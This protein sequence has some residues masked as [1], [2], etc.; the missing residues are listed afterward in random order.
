VIWKEGLAYLR[1][2]YNGSMPE[3]AI[4]SRLGKLIK[5]HSVGRVLAAL[6]EAQRQN[7]IDPFEYALGVLRRPPRQGFPTTR[8]GSAI[9]A[10]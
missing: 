10:I 1:R 4:R 3:T 2:A 7:P 9:D 6:D 8:S 5:D